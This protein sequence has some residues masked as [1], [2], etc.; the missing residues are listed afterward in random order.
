ML[1]IYEDSLVLFRITL[2]PILVYSRHTLIEC[3]SL[4]LTTPSRLEFSF[5]MFLLSFVMFDLMPASFAL[6]DIVY[7]S[8][9]RFI[10]FKRKVLRSEHPTVIQPAPL[11][12]L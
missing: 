6:F 12:E 10:L 8:P 9:F 1:D 3:L 4:R 2:S 7:V 11:W 5:A